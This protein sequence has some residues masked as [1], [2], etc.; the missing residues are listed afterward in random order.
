VIAT[1]IGKPVPA[2]D[3]FNTDTDDFDKGKKQL[4]TSSKKVRDRF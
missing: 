2:E 1:T 3:A 4:E